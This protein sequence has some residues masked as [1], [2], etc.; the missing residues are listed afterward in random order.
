MFYLVYIDY[1]NI[2][3]FK[4]L[5]VAGVRN[6]IFAIWNTWTSRFALGVLCFLHANYWICFKFRVKKE[7]QFT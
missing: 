4:N 7:I 3:I 6:P 5:S 2:C 1:S